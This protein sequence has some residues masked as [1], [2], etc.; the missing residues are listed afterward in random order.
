V[1]QL[2]VNRIGVR[3]ALMG[4]TTI[5]LTGQGIQE[6]QELDIHISIVA[7]VEVDARTA[8]RKVTGWL[9]SEVG[10]MLMGGTPQLMIGTKTVWRVPV[11]LTSSIVGMVGQVGFVDIDG[12]TGDLLLYDELIEQIL[13]NVEH[14]NSSTLSPAH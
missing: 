14:L 11:I 2:Q 6:A 13:K 7:A 5:T 10:N 4:H 9:V 8:R 3:N 12:A 1:V